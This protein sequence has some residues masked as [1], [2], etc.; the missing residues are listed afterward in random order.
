MHTCQTST[1]FENHSRGSSVYVCG[2]GVLERKWKIMQQAGES[3]MIDALFS[4]KESV[5]T[6]KQ[7]CRNV[8]TEKNMLARY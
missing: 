1:T 3:N 5:S 6:T 8:N 4:T 7:K 2:N